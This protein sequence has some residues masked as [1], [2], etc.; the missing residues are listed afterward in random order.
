LTRS[1]HF[2][3]CPTHLCVV[4]IHLVVIVIIYWTSQI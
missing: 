1:Y 3:W 2:K 4:L